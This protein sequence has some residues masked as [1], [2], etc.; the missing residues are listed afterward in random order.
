MMN[1]RSYQVITKPLRMI[2]LGTFFNVNL[3]RTGDHLDNVINYVSK[4][5][6]KCLAE[7]KYD[8]ERSQVNNNLY[9]LNSNYLTASL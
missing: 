9:L 8:G 7:M 2:T 3:C 1:I 4:R 5:T 6:L